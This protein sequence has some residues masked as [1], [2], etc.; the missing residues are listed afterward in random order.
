MLHSSG[1][2]S[3]T[4]ILFFHEGD[5]WYAIHTFPPTPACGLARLKRLVFPYDAR[6]L[7]P[8][9]CSRHEKIRYLTSFLSFTPRGGNAHRQRTHKIRVHKD[10][11]I[12]TSKLNTAFLKS[13]GSSLCTPYNQPFNGCRMSSEKLRKG[14]S[15]SVER[16]LIKLLENSMTVLGDR[17]RHNEKVSLC[18]TVY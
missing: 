12:P 8:A 17:D 2:Q 4:H 6:D 11:K 9:D 14:I 5:C 13:K 3:D 18:V 1:L 15:I 16:N 10:T 7:W